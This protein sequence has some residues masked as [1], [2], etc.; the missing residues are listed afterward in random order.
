MKIEE[1]RI[2]NLIR[3]NKPSYEL[4]KIQRNVV[5][6]SI[7]HNNKNNMHVIECQTGERTFIKHFKPIRITQKWLLKFGFV[8]VKKYNYAD[9]S[10]LM[11]NGLFIH[12]NLP[13]YEIT[14]GQL[15]NFSHCILKLKFVHQLQNFYF[16][17]IG[18]DLI[19]K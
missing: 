18:K 13:K 8:D 19:L 5:V 9:Y 15:N 4:L 17:I 1:L 16:S 2:G 6:K 3:Y 14:I 12:I 7:K 11:N 10:L